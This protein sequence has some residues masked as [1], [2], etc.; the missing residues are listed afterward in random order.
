MHIEMKESPA[1]IFAHPAISKRALRYA[2][3]IS[4]VAALGGFLFGFETAVI[5][6]AEK[7]IQALWQLSSGW[8]GF[9]VASSLIGTVVGSLIAGMPAQ[10]YGRKKVLTAIAILYL[11]SAIGCALTP[12]WILFITFR[13][14]GGLAVG[15][16]SVVGPMYISEVAPARIRGR[17]AGS[18]Q[19]MIVA[20]IFTAY[21]TN[22]MFADF[23][24][25]GWRW[26]L[27]IMIIPSALFAIL[28]RLIPESPRWLILKNRD[29]EAEAIFIRTGEPHAA[30]IAKEE[31][32]LQA[33]GIKE[34]LFNGKYG[35]PILYAV[36]LAM[37]NQL[38]GINAILYYAPRIF[39]MAGFDKADS[40]LQPVYIGAANLLFTM[41]AMTVIDKFGRKTLLLIGCVGLV[42]F[43]SLTAH[44]FS[45][46]AMGKNVLFYLLG[47]I[48]FFAFSQGAVLWVFV[49]EIFPNSVRSQG[50]SLGSFTHWIMAAI[51]SWTFPI[52]VEGSPNGGFYSF[53]FYAVMM[54]LA[55]LF[56]WKLLPETKGRSLEQIQKELGIK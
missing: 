36:L 37:F 46:A 31:H 9:T 18:F 53:V 35:K 12:V 54:V 21:L 49:S 39:E 34:N 22:F 11:L 14:I 43:L 10:R 2:V 15:A 30:S 56:I 26:M 16:S 52:I 32:Q 42:L 27:G 5:S 23:G 38:S 19:L 29:E 20:G 3:G 45:G 8:Q 6:G 28:V 55:F 4:M 51:I 25:S 24:D 47:Y 40:Y 7:T 41:L 50:S 13:F 1:A 17:L 33:G 48:A 44:A